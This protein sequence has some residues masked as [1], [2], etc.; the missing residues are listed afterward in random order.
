MSEQK[1]IDQKWYILRAVAGQEKKVKQ[2]LEKEVEL[3]K[4]RDYLSEVLI[5]VEK[6]YQIRKTK[7]GKS[8]KVATERTLFPGYV[9]IHADLRNGELLHAIKNVPGVLGFLEYEEPIGEEKAS[10]S[11]T[12]KSSKSK[13]GSTKTT[14]EIKDKSGLLPRPLRESEVNRILGKVEE[15]VSGEI[16]HDHTF[17]VGET[18]K[19]MDGGAFNGFTGVI[20]EVMKDRKRLRVTVKIFGRNAPVELSYMQ[21]EKVE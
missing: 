14:K 8:K 20:E 11:D 6:V 16:K 10:G 9:V 19:V 4:L 15:E 3:L 7:D 21:V 12:K 1:N 13:K 5:P 2:Y 17:V 18:V